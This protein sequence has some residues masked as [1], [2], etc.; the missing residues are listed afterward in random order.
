MENEEETKDIAP[1]STRAETKMSDELI[2]GVA[3][4]LGEDWLKLAAKLGYKDSKDALEMLRTWVVE[5]EDSTAENL[6]YMLEGLKLMEAAEYLKS[7]IV[8][9]EPTD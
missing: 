1:S 5:D 9:T 6:A 3:E 4:R 7:T 2:E 8:K